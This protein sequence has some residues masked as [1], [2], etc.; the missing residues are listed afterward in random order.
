MLNK[1]KLKKLESWFE[2]YNPDF[3]IY[4]SDLDESEISL[5]WKDYED[6]LALL[7]RAKKDIMVGDDKKNILFHLNMI[8]LG[9]N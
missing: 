1:K 9:K 6:L 8:T 3:M 2:T 7:D 5:L 4:P